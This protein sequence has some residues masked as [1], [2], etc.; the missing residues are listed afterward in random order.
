M[1]KNAFDQVFVRPRKNTLTSGMV[2]YVVDDGPEYFQD[3]LSV[4]DGDFDLVNVDGNLPAHW[5]L[6]VEYANNPWISVHCPHDQP[7]TIFSRFVSHQNTTEVARV[8]LAK[9][10]KIEL[11]KKK[12]YSIQF[13][14]KQNSPKWKLECFEQYDVEE[15]VENCQDSTEVFYTILKTLD[16]QFPTP[17][18]EAKSKRL[19]L[20][21]KNGKF[22]VRQFG[23]KGIKSKTKQSALEE[24]FDEAVNKCSPCGISNGI[25]AG[26]LKLTDSDPLQSVLM[27]IDQFA[28][29]KQCAEI[30]VDAGCLRIKA[31]KANRK[32]PTTFLI[33]PYSSTRAIITAL[34]FLIEHGADLNELQQDGYSLLHQ[35]ILHGNDTILRFLL[36]N[37]ADPNQK[38]GNG[39][40]VAATMKQF[41]TPTMRKSLAILEKSAKAPKAP[42]RQAKKKTANQKSKVVKKKDAVKKTIEV[43]TRTATQ[44][45][46]PSPST[47]TS[48]PKTITLGMENRR[49]KQVWDTR[50]ALLMLSVPPKPK[51]TRNTNL[52]I[53]P[54]FNQWREELQ[55]LGF[56]HS[57]HFEINHWGVTHIYSGMTNEKSEVDAI[58]TDG[59]HL[60]LKRPILELGSY[61]KDGST[62]VVGNHEVPAGRA[63]KRFIAQNAEPEK[64]FKTLLRKTKNKKLQKITKSK[65]LDRFKA[66]LQEELEL[67]KQAAEKELQ[68]SKLCTL[69]G[70]VPRFE[71]TGVFLWNY[72]ELRGKE[73]VTS[74]SC[75]ADNQKILKAKITKKNSD[76]FGLHRR[77]HAGAELCAFR[78][79]QYVGAP[80]NNRYF[81]PALESGIQFFDNLANVKGFFNAKE[82]GDIWPATDLCFVW[83]L[84]ALKDRWKDI[85]TIANG[86][87]PSFSPK[88]N[89]TQHFAPSNDFAA[90]MFVMSKEFSQ[91]SKMLKQVKTQRIQISKS[92]S[93][94]I[95]TLLRVWDAI[96]KGNQAKMNS[97]F[98]KCIELNIEICLEHHEKQIIIASHSVYYW[99]CWPE[100]LLILIAI[101]RGLK[102][103]KLPQ[104]KREW[105]ITPNSIGL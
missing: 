34:K 7:G 71:R 69:D 102:P 50:M 101:H 73:S 27:R 49:F 40:T 53:Y 104:Q 29:W 33:T 38:M 5:Y 3:G 28:S 89:W 75:G 9:S 10:L 26:A 61:S 74:K 31:D 46:K 48:L 1:G 88:S 86:I 85:A 6:F 32:S 103:P 14:A 30:L 25:K 62:I 92:N 2:Q 96:V 65:L 20:Q 55:Q 13:S 19:T 99:A 80:K 42:N 36:K 64:L 78:H 66:I 16:L 94:Y 70:S 67:Q 35:S 57:H 23:F 97:E 44:K 100:S 91:P 17:I 58:F 98:D 15:A 8:T 37:G 90:F 18:I 4:Y 93:P 41:N 87:K 24:R 79:L 51:R 11:A 22:K 63:V 43:K 59:F 77:I 54:E 45:S 76:A 12:A 105:L 39:K 52:E 60:G 72:P 56:V 47:S 21:P 82:N 81:E 95:K 68:K 84:A 83:V